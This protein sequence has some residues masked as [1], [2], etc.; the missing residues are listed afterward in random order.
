MDLTTRKVEIVFT[1]GQGT[2]KQAKDDAFAEVIASL[3]EH[4]DIEQVYSAPGWRLLVTFDEP[5]IE[6]VR[7]RAQAAGQRYAMLDLIV[8]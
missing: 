3:G 7:L 8:R 4:A 1:A 2:T 5:E 6:Q